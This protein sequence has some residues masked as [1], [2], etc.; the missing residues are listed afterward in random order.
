MGF[1]PKKKKKKKKEKLEVLCL[2]ATDTGL[3]RFYIVYMHAA[4]KAKQ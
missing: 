4:I 3:F 2:F 1:G